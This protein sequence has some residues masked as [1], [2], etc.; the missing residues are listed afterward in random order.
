MPDNQMTIEP[1]DSEIE[2]AVRFWY[3]RGTVI[4]TDDERDSMRAIIIAARITGRL[5]VLQGE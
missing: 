4:V 1:T 5:K 2:A 3:G